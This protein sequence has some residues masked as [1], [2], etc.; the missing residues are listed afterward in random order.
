MAAASSGDPGGSSGGR[1]LPQ[2]MDPS[3]EFGQLTF[4][5]LSGKDEATLPKNPFLIG[6][7]VEKF[8]GGSIEGA[9]SE[10]QGTRYTLRVRNPV[11]VKKLLSMTKLLDGTEVTVQPHPSL[12]VSRCVISCFDLISLEE[13]DILNGLQTQGVIKVQRITRNVNGNRVNTPAVILTYN[14]CSYPSHVKIGLLRIATRPYYPNPLLCYGCFRFGHP[15]ARC[16]GPQRCRNCSA[17]YHGEECGKAPHCANCDEAHS[18]TSRECPEYQKEKAVIKLKI[19]LNLSYPEARKRVASD[20]GSYAAVTTQQNKEKQKL[21]I[22]E[23][24]MKE[25]DA[26]IAKL[27]EAIKKKDEQIEKMMANIQNT[28]AYNENTSADIQQSNNTRAEHSKTQRDKP[29]TEQTRKPRTAQIAA[30]NMQLRN[31]SSTTTEPK[32]GETSKKSKRI[33]DNENAKTETSPDRQSPPLKKIN[34]EETDTADELIISDDCEIDETPP[35][36][37]VRRASLQ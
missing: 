2:Y 28:R 11:Q 7:S 1:R 5:Q 20:L 24:R 29:Q 27:L 37:H 22:L 25:K 8:L 6:T 31:R 30:S 34:T 21:N 14:K 18:S 10:A 33:M 36:Q 16:P 35:S 12:N 13:E 17:E 32:H 19:D 26:Q 15:R 23:K 4:L 9:A 3:N